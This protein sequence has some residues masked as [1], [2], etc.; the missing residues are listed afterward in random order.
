M[1]CAARSRSASE[2]TITPALPPSSSVT[3]FF[4]SSPLRYH[5]I[6]EDPVKL[7]LRKRSS[8]AMPSATLELTGRTWYIPAGR[9]VS[10]KNSARRS[11]PIG[12]E[13]AGLTT[14][15]APTARSEE[16]TSELQSRQYLVCRLLLE[17][18]KP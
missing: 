12:V 14:I 10:A 9:S 5:P 18:T 7:I 11:E 17:K 15:G 1:R 4:G 13:L 2:C 6:S 16:H 3:C 8:R